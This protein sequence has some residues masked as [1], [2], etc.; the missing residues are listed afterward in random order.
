MVAVVTQKLPPTIQVGA[1]MTHK[2]DVVTAIAYSKPG[3]K[4]EVRRKKE[5]IEEQAIAVRSIV[6]VQ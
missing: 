3:S 1:R 4:S 2:L 5:T 6:R